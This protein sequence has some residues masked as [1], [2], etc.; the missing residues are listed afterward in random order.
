MTDAELVALIHRTVVDTVAEVTRTLALAMTDLADQAATGVDWSPK[1]PARP[2][3][4]VVGGAALADKA[5][6]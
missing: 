6:R 5:R 2:A 3:L 1:G 4:K